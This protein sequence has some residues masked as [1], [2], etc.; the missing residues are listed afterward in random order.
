MM[1]IEVLASV[2][3]VRLFPD[4]DWTVPTAFATA[5]LPDLCDASCAEP[6]AQSKVPSR[7]SAVS[8]TDLLAFVRNPVIIRNRGNQGPKVHIRTY[9][10]SAKVKNRQTCVKF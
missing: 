5:A 3:M 7:T 10:S 6:E 1:F 9:T 4:I 2:V 8:R